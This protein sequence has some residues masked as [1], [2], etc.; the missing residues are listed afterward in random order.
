MLKDGFSVGIGMCIVMVLVLIGILVCVD[1]VMIGEI[2]LCGQVFVIGGFKE[3]LFVVYCGGIKIVL[4]LQE[5][6]W[7]FKEILDKIKEV[8]DI[9]LVKWIDQVLELVLMYIFILLSE[10]EVEEDFVLVEEKVQKGLEWFS[11]Y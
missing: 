7:D 6:E 3:K 1:V 11:I 9:W 2:I 10:V 5:N 8:L 4:I